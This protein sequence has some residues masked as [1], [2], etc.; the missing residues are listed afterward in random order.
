VD[1]L[2]LVMFVTPGC[3]PVS[4]PRAKAP[5][6]DEFGMGVGSISVIR[7]CDVREV[8]EEHRPIAGLRDVLR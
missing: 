4:W 8:R 1:T 7:G 3:L 6:G 2:L 5:Q